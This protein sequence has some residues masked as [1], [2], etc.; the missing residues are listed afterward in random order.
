MLLR[1][2]SDIHVFFVSRYLFVYAG[3]VYFFIFWL[4][5][6]GFRLRGEAPA[7]QPNQSTTKIRLTKNLSF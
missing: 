4:L 7:S 2:H 1:N 3:T 6:F 5:F